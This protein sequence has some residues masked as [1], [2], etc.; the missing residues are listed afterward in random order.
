MLDADAFLTNPDTLNLLIS[1]NKTVVAPLLTSDGL[2]SNFWA[3][4]ASNYYYTRT[5]EY[6]PIVERKEIG[7][8]KVPMVHS[9]LLINMRKLESDSLTYDSENLKNYDGPTDDIITFALSANMSGVPLHVCNDEIYGRILV[10]LASH[11]PISKD[12][13]QLTN[14]KLDLLGETFTTFTAKR[15]SIF[16]VIQYPFYLFHSSGNEQVL[17]LND[18]LKQYVE[19]PSKSTLG[20]DK[21]YMINLE[22]RPERRARMEQCFEELGILAETINAVDGRFVFLSLSYLFSFFINIY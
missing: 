12:I 14:L 20:F 7:C 15:L 1:K 17:R 13:D 19:Y 8:H 9:A 18:N 2:Y 3:G 10:P 21:I 16:Y 11:D 4:M 6:Q 22:R 5:E